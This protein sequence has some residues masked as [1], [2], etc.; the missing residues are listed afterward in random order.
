MVFFELFV[1][2]TSG[3]VELEIRLSLKFMVEVKVEDVILRVFFVE[4]IF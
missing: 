3:D 1:M 4:I 2:H